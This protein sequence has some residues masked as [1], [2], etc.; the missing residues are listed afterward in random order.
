MEMWAIKG[1]Y[2]GCPEETIDSFDTKDKAD[3]MLAEY[4]MAFGPGWIL[5]VGWLRG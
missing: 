1:K 3:R 2:S 5:Y 4:R